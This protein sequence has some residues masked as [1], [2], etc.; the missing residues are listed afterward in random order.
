MPAYIYTYTHTK[1]SHTTG[2]RRKTNPLA[3]KISG[4]NLICSSSTMLPESKTRCYPSIIHNPHPTPHPT[5][6]TPHPAPRTPQSTPHTAHHQS[7]GV[8][9]ESQS[10]GSS[11]KANCLLARQ[12]IFWQA[13]GLLAKQ[14]NGSGTW[15]PAQTTQLAQAS[16]RHA[17]KR[18]IY[19]KSD[20]QKRLVNSKRDTQKRLIQQQ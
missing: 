16:N 2:G 14:G 9:Q 3:L 6:H 19:S 8:E 12:R 17:Q 4:A 20:S 15:R 18:Q 7:L 11:D 10:K 1:G 13:K 5:P